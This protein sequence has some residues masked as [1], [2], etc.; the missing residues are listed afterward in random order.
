LKDN[1]NFNFDEEM[2]KNS[3]SESG[4][5]TSLLSFPPHRYLPYNMALAF[6]KSQLFGVCV[7]P[8]TKLTGRTVIV[9]GANIGLGV[10]PPHQTASPSL[11]T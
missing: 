2:E 4:F 3:R 9:T 5:R 7:G 1:R 6:I 11:T 8:T 10:C